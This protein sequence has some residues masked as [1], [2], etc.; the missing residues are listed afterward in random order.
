MSGR[1]RDPIWCY[2]IEEKTTSGKGFKAKC[3]VCGTL[4]MGLVA[5]MKKHKEICTAEDQIQN[6]AVQDEP[7]IQACNF[8]G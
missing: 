3:K 5:R 7:G 4:M 8:A 6:D 1:K 2:F